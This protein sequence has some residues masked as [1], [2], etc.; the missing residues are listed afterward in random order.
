MM[1]IRAQLDGAFGSYMSGAHTT[2]KATCEIFH[3]SVDLF[4]LGLAK[5]RGVTGLSLISQRNHYFA[6]NIFKQGAQVLEA[7]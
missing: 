7:N 5:S 6:P 2:A 1:E 4:T 3:L